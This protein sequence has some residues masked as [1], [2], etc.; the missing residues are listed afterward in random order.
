MS[1]SIDHLGK[2]RISQLLG[3]VGSIPAQ[4][5]PAG[6]VKLYDWR[7]PHYLNADQLNRLAAVVSQVSARLAGVLTRFFSKE[8]DVSPKAV[9]QHFGVDL[10]RCFDGSDSYC[11]TFGPEKSQDKGPEKGQDKSHACG[12]LAISSQTTMDWV[13]RLLGDTDSAAGPNR[14]LS[15]LEESLLSD[16]VAAMLDVFLASLRPHETLRS[17]GRLTKGEPAIQFERTEEICRIAFQVKEA[18]KEEPSHLVFVLTCSR[19]TALV[20]KTP[21]AVSRA[22]PQELSQM[23][24]EHLQQMPVTITARLA[25]AQV[26]FHEILDLAPGDILLL[27]KPVHEM[28]DLTIEGRP[29]FRGRPAQS[30]GRYAI[31][32]KESQNDRTTESPR[33]KTPGEPKK[34]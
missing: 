11:L 21:P 2:A 22:T 23:L 13:S 7:D 12:L 3:A 8:F 6:E 31:F 14:S 24:M 25:T 27:D 30:G 10:R 32:I 34:G 33:P 5:Q 15:S 20:G 26:G 16:L 1:P 4:E 18:E 28:A 19:L 29:V 17:N 9:T